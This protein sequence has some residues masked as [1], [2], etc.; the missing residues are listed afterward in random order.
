DKPN[1]LHFFCDQLRFDVIGALNN[2]VIKT[3]NLDRL[4]REGTAFTSAYSA[5]PECVPARASMIFGQYPSSTKCYG[6]GS[7]MPF[8]D[9]ETMMSALG[10]AGYYCHGVGKCH[11][12]PYDVGHELHGF[13]ARERQEEITSHLERDEYMQ[14]LH[15]QGY[16]YVLDPHGIRGDMYYVP[17]PAQMP[18]K[19]HPTQW[20]GDRSVAFVESRK[21]QDQPWYLFSSFIHP[22]PPFCPPNPWHKLYRD[23]DMP[24]PH[25]PLG[26]EDLLIYI[27]RFQNRYKRRDRGFD[28]QLVRM[29]RAYYYACV[30]F[31]DYQVGRVLDAL[32]E[33]GQLDNTMI[34]FMSD[35]GELLGDFGSFGKRS[36]HDAPSRIPML[37]RYP[38]K[39]E[40]GAQCDTPVGHVDVTRTI[41]DVAGAKIE[42]HDLHGGNMI[43]IAGGADADRVVFSQLYSGDNAIYTAVGKRW[44]YVY[45]APDQRELLFDRKQDPTE[46]HD[47]ANRT[48]NQK[49]ASVRAQQEMRGRLIGMLKDTGESAALDGDDWKEYPI[50]E[51]PANPDAGM[52]YQDHPWADQTIPG[53]SDEVDA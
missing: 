11:F 27:N 30:S 53:Y 14:Y 37:V 8:D 2:P 3:P 51:L 24:M 39:I 20:V 32:E 15:G 26:Y 21:G 6:N 28:L 25:M 52:L 48:W 7:P 36:Y 40:A 35:H 42:T 4:V 33:T 29:M 1:I 19:H 5:S 12:E 34:F 44:K 45:S 18:A 47:L 17:Q 50:K 49:F 41:L 23:M 31:I 46:T 10:R 16:D 9:K 38:G 13:D 43:D 22:H